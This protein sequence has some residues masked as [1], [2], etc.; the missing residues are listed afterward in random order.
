RR[1]AIDGRHPLTMG[2]RRWRAW[3][4][5]IEQGRWTKDH[6]EPCWIDQAVDDG[7]RAE[8]SLIENL[9]REDLN[10]MEVGEA[11]E[12]LAAKYG[13]ANR[14]IAERVGCTAE[15]VQQHRRLTKLDPEDQEGVRTGRWSMHDALRILANPKPEPLT[16]LELLMVAEVL[17]KCADQ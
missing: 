3:G 2:E 16:S 13:R 11:F 5:L 17:A 4:L 15:Y 14:E 9:Q 8:G 12:V 1:E 6:T 10:H 7:M